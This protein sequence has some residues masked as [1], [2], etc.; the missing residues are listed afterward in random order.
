MDIEGKRLSR[1]S[2]GDAEVL[3]KDSKR[4]LA[5]LFL[6]L[7]A[8]SVVLDVF[9]KCKRA[10]LAAFLLSA[11]GFT[12]NIYIFHV[13]KTMAEIKPQAEKQLGVVEI[14]FSVLQLIATFIHFILL[15]SDVKYSY[16]AS[17]L[18]PLAFAII[19]IVFVFKADEKVTNSSVE[20]FSNVKFLSPN[21]SAVSSPIELDLKG[22]TVDHANSR[23]NLRLRS[24]QVKEGPSIE[25]FQITGEAAPGESLVG[26]GYGI[27]GTT[28]VLFQWVRHLE[29]GTGQYIEGATTPE[30][31]VTAD[32]IDTVIVL[33]CLPI[34]DQGR[35]G[36]LVKAFA[37]EH[38]KIK[39]DTSMQREIDMHIS[40]G[41]ATFSVLLMDS[42]ETWTPITLILRQSSYQIK[43]QSTG[44][45]IIEENF[46]W[47]FAIKIPIGL[48][49]Q[50]I[51]TFS[52]GASH[53][54]STDS[55]RTRERDTI[56]LAMRM[57]HSKA[58][59][60]MRK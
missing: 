38:S 46:S 45:V 19:A 48:P 4:V 33:E 28:N 25:G 26:C 41:E 49:T 6:I 17:V 20:D 27:N 50:F 24:R 31:V 16:N 57:F 18:F 43:F 59:N 40:R 32:D 52:D 23:D 36:E 9:A 55:A 54:F 14:V 2:G 3:G 11:F 21:D 7:E 29:D 1:R 39:C 35:K 34:D 8:L 13:E 12:V 60:E 47:K 42:S 56:V 15:V 22:S 53:T 5:A 37:N 44:A 10:S 58:L 30:Y 51:L